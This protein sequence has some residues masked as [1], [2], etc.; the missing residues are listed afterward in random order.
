[1][2]ID[3]LYKKGKAILKKFYGYDDFRNNQKNVIRSLLEKNNTI[4]IMPTGAGK[5]ICFQI[6]ALLFDGITIVISP[7]IS[8]MKDQVDNLKM[9]GIPAVMLNSSLS[10][11]E[12]RENIAGI[13]ADFYKIIYLSPE[14]LDLD[15]LPKAIL[16]KKISFLAIDE[17]HCLSQW[18][19]DFRPAYL[20]ILDFYQ[21]LENKP[22]IGAF[23]ATATEIVKKDIIKLLNLKNPNVF[24]TGFDRENLNFKVVKD[25]NKDNFLLKFLDDH[26]KQS[27][28]IYAQ[29]RKQV[30]AISSMLNKNG[31]LAGRYHAGMDELDRKMMQEDFLYDR[32][33]IMV[34]TNAF[35]MGIDKSNVRFV[36][37]YG[38]P[39][40]MEAYYQEAGRAGR[41]GLNG[42][43]ILL[44]NP[45]DQVIQ[46]Y[47][48]DKSD[49]DIHLK[50]QDYKLLNSMVNYCYTN[51]CLR[52]YI[53]NYFGDNAKGEKCNFCSNCEISG[54]YIDYTLYAQ[55]ILSCVYRM[56]ERFNKHLVAEVLKGCLNSEITKYEFQHLSTFGLLKNWHINKILEIINQL[57]KNHMLD[58][59]KDDIPILKLN[60]LSRKILKGEEKF[61]IK[62]ILITND[63]TN[64]K[65]LDDLISLRKKWAKI[66]GVPPFIIFSDTTLKEIAS[67][68]PN[69]LNELL[70]IEGITKI[71]LNQYGEDI[72]KLLADFKKGA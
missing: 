31:F 18:G 6:P 19:H 4:A 2:D 50:N 37:H 60:N 46:R 70:K 36:I 58:I 51:N 13:M 38:I 10:S 17:A 25:I 72:L 67:K 49:K 57:E 14:R 43:C 40:N 65:L 48:I 11:E 12:F 29:T 64:K 21:K 63:N 20:K 66:R 3:N 8:L 45:G 15:I 41:D 5:S 28:I 32:V 27:G 42:E 1:M 26:P 56:R 23:T 22:L 53:L 59:S 61:I 69:N 7:L 44:F 47:L 54:E 52:S 30:D 16:K 71:K 33:N 9:L 35:G 24:V 68:K 34:A 62:K 55:M 39:K